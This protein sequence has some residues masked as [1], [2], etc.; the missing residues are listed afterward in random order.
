MGTEKQVKKK[1]NILSVIIASIFAVIV[2][3]LLSWFKYKKDQ[4]NAA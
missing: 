2:V 1:E 3:G 4:G